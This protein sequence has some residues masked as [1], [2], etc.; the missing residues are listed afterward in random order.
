MTTLPLS[1]L[2]R[3]LAGADFR[4]YSTALSHLQ[5]NI[6]KSHGRKTAVHVLLTFHKT[7]GE[8]AKRFLSGLAH[9]H[10]LTN[11]AEQRKQKRRHRHG[12]SELFTALYPSARGYEYLGYPQGRFSKEFWKGIRAYR[13]GDPPPD[14]WEPHYQCDIHAMLLYAHNHPG[15]L[16]R[17]IQQ[18]QAELHGIAKVALERGE[19]INKPK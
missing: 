9:N 14:E 19:T 13:L 7:S 6:L 1:Q 16:D 5:G 8:Q 11:A 10:K 12:S 15:K 17:H 4:T 3:P 18:V 2:D